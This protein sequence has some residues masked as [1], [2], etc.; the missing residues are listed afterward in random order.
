MTIKALIGTLNN[1]TTGELSRI[2]TRIRECREEAREMG[3]P[4]VVA[5]LDDAIAMLEV[6][7]V[8]GF[9][10]KLAHAVSRLG[11]VRETPVSP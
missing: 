9:R 5:I 3:L 1:L 7:D 8:K 6:C 2:A 4:E 11:H 10:K